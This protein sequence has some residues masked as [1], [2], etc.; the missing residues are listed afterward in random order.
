M[1]DS[2]ETIDS[3][4]AAPSILEGHGGGD[5]GLMEDFVSAVANNDPQKILTEPEEILESHRIVFAAER[6][7]RE[8]RIVY[9]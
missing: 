5:L 6:S 3:K 4:L 2:T 8:G 1:T 9:L 7:R